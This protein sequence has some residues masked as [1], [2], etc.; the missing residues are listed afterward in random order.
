MLKRTIS[1]TRC[2]R[3]L[4]TFSLRRIRDAIAKKTFRGWG[5]RGGPARRLT[6][7]STGNQI[8]V[9]GRFDTHSYPAVATLRVRRAVVALVARA[10]SGTFLAG[11]YVASSIGCRQPAD[12]DRDRTAAVARD[13][14]DRERLPPPFPSERDDSVDPAIA[15]PAPSDTRHWAADGRAIVVERSSERRIG[16]MFGRGR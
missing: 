2:A 8:A 4:P 7:P 5:N 14:L 13:S 3:G 1:P 12:R 6:R 15:P 9:S 11:V 10:A 16:R